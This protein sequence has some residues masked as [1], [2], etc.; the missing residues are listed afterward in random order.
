MLRQWLARIAALLDDSPAPAELLELWNSKQAEIRAMLSRNEM[1]AALAAISLWQPLADIIPALT[2][3][4]AEALIKNNGS[5]ELLIREVEDLLATDPENSDLQAAAAMF[6]IHAGLPDKGVSL[7]VQAGTKSPRH[8]LL[9]GE[10]GDELM[11][12]GDLQSALAAFEK[13][14]MAQ[15]QCHAMLRS[16]G[17]CYLRLKM[18]EA[19]RAAYEAVLR[20]APG[21]VQAKSALLRL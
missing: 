8:G 15:P 3:I 11:A 20:Q 9:W 19:A 16:M 17:D 12:A 14:F 21:D 7:L 4:R 18:P 5:R 2:I 1:D 6:F 10:L 13:G